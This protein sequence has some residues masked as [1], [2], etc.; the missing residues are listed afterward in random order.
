MARMVFETTI[1]ASASEIVKALDTSDG[2]AGWW[3]EEVTFPG[4][5]GSQMTLG[6]P[7]MAPFPF[8]LRVD[9]VSESRV[10]WTSV[11]EFP[12]HWVGTGI[13]WT[14][15]ASDDGTLVHFCHD[16]WANDEGPF[17]SSALTW[18]QLMGSLKSYVEDGAGMPL[19]RKS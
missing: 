15:T 4:G 14:L 18:G 11:G 7:H 9:E 3:T 10:R 6:F 19:Y 17:P 1:N 2:I 8:E 12:P 13:T 5:E 16:G